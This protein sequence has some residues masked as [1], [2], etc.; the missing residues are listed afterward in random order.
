MPPAVEAGDT[1]MGFKRQTIDTFEYG[2]LA[3][4]RQLEM[5]ALAPAELLA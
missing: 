2:M 3:E 1:T 5:L 4:Q